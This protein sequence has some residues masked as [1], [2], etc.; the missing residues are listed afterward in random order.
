MQTPPQSAQCDSFSAEAE[1]GPALLSPVLE[2]CV[3][4]EMVGRLSCGLS[5]ATQPNPR[6]EYILNPQKLNS[7]QGQA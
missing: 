1:G 7:E 6:S 5:L 4:W 3:G 2:L